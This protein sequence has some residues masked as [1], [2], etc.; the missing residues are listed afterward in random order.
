MASVWP[1]VRTY[2]PAE[3][4]EL[5]AKPEFDVPVTAESRNR[6]GMYRAEEKRNTL[7]AAGQTDIA[8]FIRKCNLSMHLFE[9][10]T[11]EE[12]LRCYEL[13]VRTNQLNMSGVK[14]TPEEFE[15]VLARPEHQNFAFSCADDFGDYGIVGF[16]QYRIEN[17]TLVFTEFAMSCRVAGKFVESALFSHLLERENCESGIFTVRKTRK[18]ILLRNTLEHIGFR[19]DAQD[20]KQVGYHFGTDLVNRDAVSVSG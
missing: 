16:G 12:K 15:A 20:E 14:Y 19:A 17:T 18:N 13:T 9:P 1:Q 5:L 11:E 7:M 2:D 10:K 6:R 3:M 4:G 8:E